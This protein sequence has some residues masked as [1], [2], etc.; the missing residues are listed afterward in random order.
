M[1]IDF[2]AHVGVEPKISVS[3]SGASS[4]KRCVEEGLGFA[5]IPDWCIEPDEPNLRS[6]VLTEIPEIKVYFGHAQFLLDSIYVKS[7]YDACQEHISGQ[8]LHTAH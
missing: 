3:T 7:L 4:V 2:L 6:T 8:L 5:I 1:A